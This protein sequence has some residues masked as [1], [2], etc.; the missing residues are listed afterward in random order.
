MSIITLTTDFGLEDEYAG[1]MKGVILSIHPGANIVDITHHIHPQ[2]LIEAAHTIET[3][4]KYFP[5]G[6][7]HIVVVDPGVG[8][9]RPIIALEKSGHFFLAPD[10]GVL[11]LL[12]DDMGIDSIVHVK[13]NRYFLK[14]VSQTFHGRDIFAPVGAHMSL[15]VRINDLGDVIE[16]DHVVRLDIKKPAQSGDEISGQIISIDR[17]GNL[18]TN[19]D[20]KHLANICR[21]GNH[22]PV[23]IRI[24]GKKIAGLSYSYENSKDQ[25][26]LAI[27][28]SRGTLEIAVNK[29]S[30]QKYFMAKRGDIINV[31]I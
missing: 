22:K 19:I 9:E 7:V 15:G 31:R 28:G 8:G 25:E 18:I 6:T 16:D 5:S 20:G 30:A 11:S 24:G 10:N 21:N 4:Y 17:F 27:V 14:S 26:P 23:E 13:N 12:L 2:D 1:V 29:G 3:S